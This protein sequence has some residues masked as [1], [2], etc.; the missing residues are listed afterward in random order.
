M[1]MTTKRLLLTP[2]IP[3][4]LLALMESEER[5][6]Q[7]SGVRPAEGLRAF[8]VSDEVSKAYV[9]LL[10]TATGPD[11]WQHGFAIIHRDTNEA[12]GSVGFKGPPDAHGM[13]EI[14]YGVVPAYQGKGYAGEAA[15]AAIAYAFADP[16]V[17]LIR[18]HTMPE[19]NASTR[20][21]ARRGFAQMGE[22]VDPEDGLVWR[23]ELPR[24]VRAR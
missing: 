24:P 1:N 2:S 23:W 7:V 4:N 20:I 19:L 9:D 22:I 18:A 12:I 17:R 3:A 16:S 13:V 5:Y 8:F 15:D 14:A 11:P 6:A 21:L 10:R